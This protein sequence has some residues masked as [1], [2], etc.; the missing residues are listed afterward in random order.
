[1]SGELEPGGLTEAAIREGGGALEAKLALLLSGE[2]SDAVLFALTVAWAKTVAQLTTTD[3]EAGAW[4]ARRGNDALQLI[5]ANPGFRA[6][7][8]VA[9]TEPGRPN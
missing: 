6:A 4:L 2:R 9:L 1:M 5:K 8:P 7:A 3:A